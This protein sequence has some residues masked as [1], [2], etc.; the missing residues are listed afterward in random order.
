VRR[1]AWLILFAL[2]GASCG[3]PSN[4][5]T[6][7]ASETTAAPAVVVPA[8]QVP[9]TIVTTEPTISFV[10]GSCSASNPDSWAVET[11]EIQVTNNTDSRAAVVMG[12]YADGFTHDD[13]VAYGSDVSTRPDFIDALEIFEVGP[14]RADQLL[15]DYGPGT[16]FRVCMPET[17]TMVVLDDLTIP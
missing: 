10:D 16:Y 15:F 13:L 7:D 17:N 4:A 8:T 14:G 1:L 5:T 12:T 3:D 2:V 11:L 9:T 6:S